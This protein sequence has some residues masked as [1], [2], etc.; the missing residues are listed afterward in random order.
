[1]ILVVGE[2]LFDVFP[3][4]KKIG[5]APFNFAVHMK[6]F[7]FPVRFISRVGD[8]EEGREIIKY[9]ERYGFNSSD[10]QVDPDYPTGRVLVGIDEMGVP[11]FQILEDAAYDRID[12]QSPLLKKDAEL[13][14]YGSLIQRTV[15]SSSQLYRLLDSLDSQVV[16]FCDINLRKKCF[17]RESVIRSMEKADVLKLNYD[18]LNYVKGITGFEGGDRDL[19]NYFS[20]EFSVHRIAVTNGPDESVLFDRG[21]LVSGKPQS[22]A[23]MKDT[24]GAGDSFAAVLAAGLLNGLDMEEILFRALKF[25][26]YIC[27]I[28]GAIPE[29]KN[30]Y[31]KI[32]IN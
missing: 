23:E 15:N 9:I 30:Y 24:V 29:D 25:S 2:I 17:S 16:R 32:G 18:E 11:D 20:E 26:S 8:D 7:G 4:Y 5:G 22:P 14:Y 19:Y 27:S 1:M 21:I 12:L 6:R 13:I 28:E 31:K 3:D 10:I